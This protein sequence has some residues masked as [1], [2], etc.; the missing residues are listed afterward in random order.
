[1]NRIQIIQ[2]IL[3]KLAGHTYLEI[4]TESGISFLPIRAKRKL[5]IDPKFKIRSKERIK[6]T[7]SKMLI[8]EHDFV[9]INCSKHP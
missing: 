2:A 8:C 7:I 1:M 9:K 4:G 5:A 3:D 6:R